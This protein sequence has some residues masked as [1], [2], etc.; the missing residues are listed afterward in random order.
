MASSTSSSRRPGASPPARPSPASP[1]SSSPGRSALECAGDTGLG[2][3]GGDTTPVAVALITKNST[4]PFFVAM[5]EGAKEA[6]EEYNVDI[7]IGA[8]QRTATSRARSSRS[9]TPSPAARTGS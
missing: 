8:G 3:S 2:G 7:T 4:N 6:A 9:R 1:P 5:Q